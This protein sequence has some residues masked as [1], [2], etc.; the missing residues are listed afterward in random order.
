MTDMNMNIDAASSARAGA[1]ESEYAQAKRTIANLLDKFGFR[2]VLDAV[3]GVA[4]NKADEA[5][6]AGHRDIAR[7]WRSRVNA[8][9]EAQYR[10]IEDGSQD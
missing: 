10:M 9:D 7:R 2:L 8:I 1:L 3:A 6:T 5:Y 4:E